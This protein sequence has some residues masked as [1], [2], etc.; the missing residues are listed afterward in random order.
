MEKSSIIPEIVHLSSNIDA[1]EYMYKIRVCNMLKSVTGKNSPTRKNSLLWRLYLRSLLDVHKDFEKSRNTLFTALDE[2]PWNKA[3]YLD[4]TV[5]VPQE[6][7]HIQDL[8]IEKQLR[9]YA[10]PEELEILR[11]DDI[12][13]K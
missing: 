2:C 4:G 12:N 8:I 1:N 11:D 10:L 13:V 6:L 5:Y 7:P 9:L 3:L